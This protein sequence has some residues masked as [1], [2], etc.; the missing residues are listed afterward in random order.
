MTR[1]S[2]SFSGLGWDHLAIL[3]V[4]ILLVFSAS[5]CQVDRKH[6]HR[7]LADKSCAKFHIL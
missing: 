1:L 2:I 7:A 4:R 6:I 3:F 5:P